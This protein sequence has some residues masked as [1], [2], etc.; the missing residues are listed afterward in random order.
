[1]SNPENW[2]YVPGSINP[3]DLPS[4]GCSARQLL[5]TKWWQ[6]PPWLYYPSNNW[7]KSEFS[8][9]EEEAMKEKRKEIVSSMVS[10]QKTDNSFMYKFSS[11]SKTV[12][13]VTWIFRFINNS[14]IPRNARKCGIL[15]SEEIFKAECAIIRIIQR[16]S[17]TNEEDEKLRTL[18]V[19]KDKNDIIRLKTKILYRS[20]SEE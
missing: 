12:R 9:N 17:F 2:H 3:A 15:D 4:R 19:F 7:P 14:R 20:D 1:M 18:I 16:E 8:L 6:G 10:L 5:E 13:I 11:Y